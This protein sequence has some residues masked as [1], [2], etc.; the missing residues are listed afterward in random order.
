VLRR[1]VVFVAFIAVATAVCTLPA[2]AASSLA[3]S[4]MITYYVDPTG[5]P[6][7]MVCVNFNKTGEGH[8]VITGTWTSPSISG[9]SG[10]WAQKGQHFEWYGYYTLSGKTV[11]TFDSGDMLNPHAAS[12]TSAVA[13]IVTGSPGTLFTGTATLQTVRACS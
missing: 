3:A 5:A 4:W 12:E 2:R 7:S 9:W 11:A 1:L 13:N 6:G 10:Q 8:G